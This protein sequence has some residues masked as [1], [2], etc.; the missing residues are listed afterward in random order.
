MK[1]LL[2]SQ[3]LQNLAGV[4]RRR[5]TNLNSDNEYTVVLYILI[6]ILCIVHERYVLYY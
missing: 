2:W 4:I 1:V 5:A 3:H 6:F